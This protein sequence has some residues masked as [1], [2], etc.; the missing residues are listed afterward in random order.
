MLFEFEFSVIFV[1]NVCINEVLLMLSNVYL[2]KHDTVNMK[3][4]KEVT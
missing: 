3:S 1:R 4:M 2:V